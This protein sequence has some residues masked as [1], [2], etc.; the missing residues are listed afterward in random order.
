MYRYIG[1]YSRVP[2]V[3]QPTPIRKC[4]SSTCFREA[5]RR[6]PAILLP[7]YQNS[8][9]QNQLFSYGRHSFPRI[10]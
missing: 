2:V 1:M 8:E 3:L 9:I 10:Y 7:S 4:S 6:M 5:W